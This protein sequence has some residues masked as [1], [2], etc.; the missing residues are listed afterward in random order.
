MR[1]YLLELVRQ[2]ID[3]VE[4]EFT[5]PCGDTASV[6]EV[7]GGYNWKILIDLEA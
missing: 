3:P 6:F 1:L 5:L 4:V 7:E 2:G